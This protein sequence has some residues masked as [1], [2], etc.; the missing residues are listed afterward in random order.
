MEGD[1]RQAK[2]KT[3]IQFNCLRKR[4]HLFTVRCVCDCAVQLG[5]YSLRDDRG[6]KT[7]HCNLY[8]PASRYF[9]TG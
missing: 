5:L 1:L 6:D 9:T 2:D 3:S 7:T 4:V 8:Q